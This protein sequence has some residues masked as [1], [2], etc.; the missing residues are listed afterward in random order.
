[1]PG[2]IIFDDEVVASGEDDVNASGNLY[3]KKGRKYAGMKVRWFIL[4]N[5]GSV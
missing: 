3:I 4:K 1:M 2:T 5:E